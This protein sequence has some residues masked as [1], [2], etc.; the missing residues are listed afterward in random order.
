[1]GSGHGS[2]GLLLKLLCVNKALMKT[3][4]FPPPQARKHGVGAGEVAFLT[5]LMGILIKKEP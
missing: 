2:K 5:S 3:P 4:A 1:M